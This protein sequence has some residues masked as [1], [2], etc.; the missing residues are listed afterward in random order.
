M[1]APFS[2]YLDFCSFIVKIG[3][4]LVMRWRVHSES[5]HFD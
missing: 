5:Y 4:V 3:G 2:V 1:F